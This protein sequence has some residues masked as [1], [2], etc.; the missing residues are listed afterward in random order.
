VLSFEAVHENVDVTDSQ[1]DV[2]IPDG[3]TIKNLK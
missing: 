1:F 2:K 3:S